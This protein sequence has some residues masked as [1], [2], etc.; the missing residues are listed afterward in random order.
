MQY[1]DPVLLVVL[2]WLR[3]FFVIIKAGF[4]HL[5]T[6]T[7]TYAHT[8]SIQSVDPVSDYLY[9]FLRASISHNQ[10]LMLGT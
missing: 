6:H 2:E 1:G 3:I 8:K 10:R 7:R 5:Y 9:D 4:V